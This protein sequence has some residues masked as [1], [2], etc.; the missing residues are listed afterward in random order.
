MQI[1]RRLLAILL[2]SAL[3]ASA[4]EKTT[5]DLSDDCRGAAGACV[6]V[7]TG[8]RS[9]ARFS[10]LRAQWPRAAARSKLSPETR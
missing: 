10:A 3:P 6:V 2:C 4:Q 9:A 8:F 7:Y 1:A 5:P